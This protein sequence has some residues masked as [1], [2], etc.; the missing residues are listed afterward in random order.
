M[1]E[2]YKFDLDIKRFQPKPKMEPFECHTFEE[3]IDHKTDFTR[4]QTQRYYKLID[5][6]QSVGN[7]IYNY[8]IELKRDPRH[9]AQID[10]PPQGG[11]GSLKFVILRCA[12]EVKLGYR[13][14]PSSRK[15]IRSHEGGFIK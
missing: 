3:A 7:L 12:E 6:L 10:E 4:S 11:N 2:T 14:E 5:N 1:E 15:L 8:K 13:N 9:T